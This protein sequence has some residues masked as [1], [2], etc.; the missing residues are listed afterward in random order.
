[1]P[2][3]QIFFVNQKKYYSISRRFTDPAQEPSCLYK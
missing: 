2:L 3:C 1:M